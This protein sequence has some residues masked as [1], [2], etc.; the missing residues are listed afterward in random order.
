MVHVDNKRKKNWRD[1]TR[2]RKMQLNLGSFGLVGYR[3]SVY[4]VQSTDA[5]AT[6]WRVVSTKVGR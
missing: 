3:L 6:R 5:A 2:A 1:S 4:R